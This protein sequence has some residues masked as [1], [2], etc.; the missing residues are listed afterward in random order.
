MKRLFGKSA[1]RFTEDGGH[2]L[3]NTPVPQYA[4]CSAFS[5]NDK[6]VV[7][8]T[9][10]AINRLLCYLNSNLA[11]HS[12]LLSFALTTINRTSKA[13][14]EKLEWL[15][16][17]SKP[18]QSTTI[19]NDKSF[20]FQ[21]RQTSLIIRAMSKSAAT[22]QAKFLAIIRNSSLHQ[23][24]ANLLDDVEIFAFDIPDEGTRWKNDYHPNEYGHELVARKIWQPIASMLKE[25]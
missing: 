23:I 5:I 12:V 7:A 16:H 1:I 19:S 10:T 6:Y 13:A 18:S 3:I 25:N 22:E 11:D 2:E 15:G 14:N 17:L 21:R 9:D 8:K 4:R 20:S 24:D